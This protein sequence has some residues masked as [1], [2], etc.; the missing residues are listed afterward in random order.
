MPGVPVASVGN[1]E[2]YG[3]YPD[4]QEE[5]SRQFALQTFAKMYGGAQVEMPSWASWVRPPLTH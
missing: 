2:T 1:L 3:L 5:R 4:L